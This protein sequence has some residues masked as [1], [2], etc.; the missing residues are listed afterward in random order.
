MIWGYFRPLVHGLLSHLLLKFLQQLHQVGPE[1]FS[2]GFHFVLLRT[3]RLKRFFTNY[4]LLNLLLPVVALSS[5]PVLV[6]LYSD[7]NS[8]N[9]LSEALYYYLEI[10]VQY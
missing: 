1:G 9:L 6:G 7:L 10:L 2:L 5:N 4:L 3:R 8:L